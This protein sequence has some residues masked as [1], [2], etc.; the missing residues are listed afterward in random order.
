MPDAGVASKDFGYRYKNEYNVIETPIIFQPSRLY[1]AF[2]P[3]GSL[4]SY[5]IEQVDTNVKQL[6]DDGNSEYYKSLDKWLAP[7]AAAKTILPVWILWLLVGVGG[8]AVLLMIFGLVLRARVSSKTK[9]LKQEIIERKQVEEAIRQ[10]EA[11]Y[12]TL[13]E[14]SNDGI[15]IIRDGKLVFVNRRMIGLTA[16]SIE[17]TIGK[18]FIDFLT[19]QYRKIVAERNQRRMS[20]QPSPERYE[21]EIM[22]G[23]GNVVDVEINASR[24]EY[25]G[26]PATMAVVRDM[27]KQNQ[28]RDALQDR[29]KRLSLIYN[30][31]SDVIFVVSTQPAGT[32]RFESVNHRF[33]EVTGLT[34]NQI[35][36]KLVKDVIPEVSQPLVFG[37][38]QEAINSGK[39]AQWEEV[40]EYPTGIR[41]AE[42]TIAPIFD[43][44]G[45]C[46]QLIGTLHDITERKQS[47]K[48]LAKYREHLEGLVKQRTLELETA[49][50]HKSQFLAN[51]SHE[52]RTPLNSI[53]GYTKLMLDGLEGSIS[54]E[55][56]EDLQ[57]VYD[58]SKHLL[59][60]IN[61][62][63]DLSKIEGR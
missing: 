32:F 11:K 45:I 26:Q 58:N 33:L 14:Q 39:S 59:S 10:S 37:K 3:K 24:I 48:E 18:P 38:Y 29:E 8:I 63:L 25:A 36:G 6:K 28:I 7:Q 21:A 44:N 56:K 62:L 1:F 41:E 12:S 43:S 60:L 57:T 50:L 17:D 16:Y 23:N 52:L 34:E 15:L 4:T 42:V 61:D 19:P 22:D 30:N 20:G 49:N 47:E 13:V 40:S 5:L 35:V 9:Q 31:V 2:P 54:G 53:I 55:Q 27:T 51:M 46:T